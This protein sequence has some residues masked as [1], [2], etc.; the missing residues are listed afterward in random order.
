MDP[1]NQ[2]QGDSGFKDLCAGVAIRMAEMG[3]RSNSSV[4][5]QPAVFPGDWD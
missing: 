5:H 4:I 1:V 2:L 3:R